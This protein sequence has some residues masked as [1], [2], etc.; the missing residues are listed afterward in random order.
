M[1]LGTAR[2]VVSP[3]ALA[4]A[5][6]RASRR[7]V[8]DL[9][10]VAMIRVHREGENLARFSDFVAELK[11]RRVIRALLGWGIASFAVLQVYE[12][13][14]HG[15][16]LPEWTLSFVVVLLGLGFPVTAGLAWVFDLGPRGIER[17]P[18]AP[19]PGNSAPAGEPLPPCAPATRARARCR[20]ARLRLLLR[21]AGR[22]A[23][24]GGEG[25]ARSARPSLRGGPALRRPQ[26]PEGPRVPGGRN[27][28][29]DPERA[30]TCQRP[31][32]PRTNLVVL[33]QGEG[34]EAGRDWSGTQ[35]PDHSRGERAEGRE[36]GPGHSAT[37]RRRRRVP[38]LVRD[39]RPGPHGHLPD[40]GGDR[41]GGRI[42]SRGQA[43]RRR[44][45]E[46][47]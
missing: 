10:R 2:T 37:P 45:E 7:F 26:R 42:G 1:Q 17:T 34:R 12:P 6:A 3:L 32:G 8:A 22:G 24:G 23:P 33:V 35:R 38:P 28:R 44:R 25:V 30:R 4:P 19:L 9:A 27:C 5:L 13:V 36:P 11:R 29:G 43:P 41:P 39:I 31:S 20:R 46:G 15:L 47:K 21:L 14:M 40:R 16:H 18:P